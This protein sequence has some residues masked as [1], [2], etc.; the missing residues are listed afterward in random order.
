MKKIFFFILAIYSFGS[1]SQGKKIKILSSKISTTDEDKY[2]GATILI[3]NVKIA[4]EGATLDCKRAL[5]YQKE[6][7]FKA[8]GEVVMEQGDSIIQY[9]D[10]ATYDGNTKTAKSWSN[11]EVNDK[12]MKL[13]TDTLYFNR[14]K[15]LLYYPNG[16]TI[17]DKTN[18]LKSVKG[19][20]YTKEK[21]FTARTMV[22]VTNPDNMLESNHLDYYT[23]TKLAY[24]YGA[25]T[26]TDL[27]DSTKIYAE[28]GFYN[29]NTDVSYFV[30]K[31]TLFLKNR[32]VYADSMY[33]DK[34]KGFAS[35]TNRIKVIDTINKMV[36]K[37]NYAEIFEHKD[38]LFIVDRAVGITVKD[39]DSM[40][41]HGDT[42]MITGKPKK[43]IV[44]TFHNVK[45]FK[46][47]LQ[48][49]C[50]SI[51]SSQ[52][53][54]LTKMYKK[55]VLWSGKNQITG[56]SIH[57]L[58]NAKTEKLDSLFIY[59]KAFMVEQDS[60]NPEN[61]NQIKGLNMYGKF[62]DNK[63][64][65]LLVKGNAESI[66]FNRNEKSKKLE[67]ITK[68]IA[69]DIEFTL[70]NNEIYETKYFKKS[71]GKTYPPSKFPKDQL[72]FKGFVWREEEKPKTKEDIFDKSQE[73]KLKNIPKE[74]TKAK[75][76]FQKENTK[77]EKL[78]RDSILNDKQK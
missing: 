58:S 46:S 16:G 53:T 50:D 44:R 61:F 30:K 3:G 29:T 70:E 24:L 38:S 13:T 31:A 23:D 77:K 28:R 57:I 72:R 4:H 1:F 39:K 76:Q 32:T 45:I 69:S 54:G 62:V 74:M 71:E 65:K 33:Y 60:I 43:R 2:P 20:Y 56:D 18:T 8:V 59:K 42:I 75:K 52:I 66:Y 5:L 78:E 55:P 68:E 17:R 15:Q 12:E 21:K 7:L 9:S 63:I 27:K 67:T 41:I 14:Q 10:F 40:Y 11:V 51:H 19:T 48:G 6:N 36:T 73:K 26:I 34:R 64:K 25:S 22:T 49:K 35:A 47:N 37:G